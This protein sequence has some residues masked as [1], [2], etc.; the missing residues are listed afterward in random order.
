MFASMTLSA[1]G[2]QELSNAFK[3]DVDQPAWISIMLCLSVFYLDF[4]GVSDSGWKITLTLVFFVSSLLV[5]LGR[6]PIPDIFIA[7][8]G[9]V[10]IVY[11]FNAIVKLYEVEVYGQY[12][13]ALIFIISFST[14]VF[15]YLTG[16][17]FG[18]HKLLPSISP[19][20]TIEGSVGGIVGAALVTALYCHL[21]R[22]NLIVFIPI[23]VMGS[24][25]AQIGDLFASAIKRHNGIKDFSN[26]IPGH[27]GVLDRFDSVLFV[28]LLFSVIPINVFCR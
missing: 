13:V 25:V 11:P 8:L 2:V 5:I 4:L 19:K 20:K 9:L 1:I 28:S 10:Y 7:L 24:V 18:K 3:K 14:D 23:A 21:I 16:C 12:L 26:L 6:N 27:G 22:F 15:A 17:V